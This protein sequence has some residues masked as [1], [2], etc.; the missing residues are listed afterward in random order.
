M[1]SLL[2]LLYGPWIYENVSEAAKASQ[3][4]RAAF[5]KKNGGGGKSVT[6]SKGISRF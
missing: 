4:S 5:D 2:A 1:A 3:D 6:S